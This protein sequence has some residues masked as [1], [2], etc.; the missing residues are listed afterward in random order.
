MPSGPAEPGPGQ[1]APQD[2]Y[3]LHGGRVIGRI[4]KE[5]GIKYVFGIPSSHCWTFDTGFHEHGIRRIH[6]HHEQAGAYAADAY[7]KCTRS[8]GIFFGTSGP[9]VTNAVSGINQAWLTRSPIIGLFATH[10]WEDRGRG[11]LQE[12]YPEKVLES[13]TK[14]SVDTDDWHMLPIYL[15]W[16]L[17]DCMVY[18][19]G[20]ITLSASFR[21]LCHR[22]RSERA[23]LGNVPQDEMASPSPAQGDPSAIEKA[24][25]LLL[26]AE[27]P[28]IVAGE[29]V[30][31]A[32]AA[33]ELQGLAE[34]LQIPVNCRRIARG[35]IPEDH[36]LA[37]EGAYRTD[38][39]KDADLVIIVGLRL[40]WFEARGEPPVWPKARRIIV[41]ESATDGWAPLPTEA[42]IIG[43]TKMVLKQ[44]I[45]Y[46]LNNGG[47]PPQ[48]KAWLEQLENCRRAYQEGE[49]EDE[50]D[51]ESHQPIH[52]W[53]LS[54]E[55]VDFLDPSATIILDSWV[56]SAHL[57]DKIKASFPGQIL[58]A[59]EAGG[60]GHGIGMGIGAQLA[61]PGRQVFVLMGDAGMGIGG[62]DIETALRYNLPV[63]YLVCNQ[64]SWL[65]ATDYFFQ[66]QVDS[67][68]FSPD[69]RY[70]KMYEAIGCHSEWVTHSEEIS[71]AL[72]RAFESGKTAVV[73]VVVDDRV[74]HPWYETK[75][76]RQTIFI[77][78]LDMSKVPEPFKSYL[79]KGRTPEVEEELKKIGWPRATHKRKA[80]AYDI[81]GAR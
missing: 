26:E 30:Y 31:W 65:A 44:M 1:P 3:P 46:V 75:W 7:A 20:P 49:R 8:P 79:L 50:A 5:H 45:E 47:K 74:M 35:A 58:E 15:R 14:W 56:G 39:W 76:A 63:V 23:L 73:N 19:P 18:P 38:F 33:K 12:V 2:F 71:P 69:L 11:G 66:G 81:V 42:M 6:M 17:R 52:P 62:C 57:T 55:I 41:N 37:I 43:N 78:Q 16:A 67:W 80:A 4:L 22:G 34:L 68:K 53:I 64:G 13:M 29:G 48:K 60:F 27:R 10:C 61:R 9:G 59:G 51:Y 77:P 21:S 32:D 54:R 24:V 72:Y 70:D 40:G 28:L 25:N 36:P